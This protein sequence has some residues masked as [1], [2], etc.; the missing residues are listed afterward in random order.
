TLSPTLFPLDTHPKDLAGN[1]QPFEKDLTS[2][3]SDQGTAKTRPRP[4]GPLRDKDSGRNKPLADME[5]IYLIVADP[6]GTG[7]KYQVD[8]T[9]ST[10]LRY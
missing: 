4:E 9:Q 3:D 6:L 7:A 1:I 10:K 2:T 5:P 8:Q